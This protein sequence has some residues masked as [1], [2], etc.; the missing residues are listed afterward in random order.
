MK[1][2]MIMLF[3]F[4]TSI[5]NAQLRITTVMNHSHQTDPYAIPFEPQFLRFEQNGNRLTYQIQGFV[6]SSGH[7]KK[8]LKKIRTT[9][10]VHQNTLSIKHYVQTKNEFGKEGVHIIGYNFQQPEHLKIQKS[11]KKIILTMY[12]NDQ[13]LIATETIVLD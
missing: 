11:I 12:N 9:K 6:A 7:Y 2:L 13:Q 10:E 4:F 1:L 8:T 3:C 5:L